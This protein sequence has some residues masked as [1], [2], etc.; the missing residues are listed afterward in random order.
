MCASPYGSRAWNPTIEYWM[1]ARFRCEAAAVLTSPVRS[2]SQEGG[3]YRSAGSKALAKVS[4]VRGAAE[5]GLM[6]LRL[7]RAEM[8]SNMVEYICQTTACQRGRPRDNQNDRQSA[9]HQTDR[10]WLKC[11]Q[12]AYCS[13]HEP[14]ATVAIVKPVRKACCNQQN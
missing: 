1:Q 10:T 4:V 8:R 14:L 3:T 9:N 11:R 5:V 13:V 2:L 7:N 6:C 12:I